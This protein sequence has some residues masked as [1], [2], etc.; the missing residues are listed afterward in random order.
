[1]DLAVERALPNYREIDCDPRWHRFLLGI[2]PYT[3]EARQTL[4][5]A[6][7]ARSDATAVIAFFRAFMREVGSRTQAPSAPS[8]RARLASSNNKPI[9]SRAQ[10]AGLYER[11]RKG[12]FA[13]KEAE[14]ARMENDIC[15]ANAEGRV[16]NP[17]D[18]AGK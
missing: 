18:I 12:E 1:L 11:H 14:W 16:L 13:G 7:I 17:V 9:Y 2:D 3:G 5:N 6:A 4:L 10:I 8:S 15:K